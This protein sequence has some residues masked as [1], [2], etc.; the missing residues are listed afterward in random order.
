MYLKRDLKDI[1]RKD[2]KFFFFSF[3]LLERERERREAKRKES[4]RVLSPCENETLLA[5]GWGYLRSNCVRASPTFSQ[6]LYG[7]EKLREYFSFY[8]PTFS[9]IIPTDF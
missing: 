8:L 6:F 4:T 9:N 7:F 1:I 2:P 3:C 5:D